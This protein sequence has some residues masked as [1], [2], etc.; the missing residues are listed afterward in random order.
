M[1]GKTQIPMVPWGYSHHTRGRRQSKLFRVESAAGKA[2]LLDRGMHDMTSRRECKNLINY[3]KAPPLSNTVSNLSICGN[4]CK[5]E[6]RWWNS[7][8]IFSRLS[9]VRRGQFSLRV[10]C[11]GQF[12][13]GTTVK[14]DQCLVVS[15]VFRLDHSSVGVRGWLKITSMF[16]CLA[17][18]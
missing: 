8:E 9:A 7:P 18:H 13:P 11:C 3:Q 17:S 5:L 10:P 14:R 2:S 15:P 1:R 12:S 16:V 6:R 4:L